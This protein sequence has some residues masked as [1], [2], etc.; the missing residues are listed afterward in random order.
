MHTIIFANGD[1]PVRATAQPWLTQADLIV[2]ADGGARHALAIGVTP[3]IVIGDLDSIDPG[4][5]SKLEQTGARF[6]VYPAHKD[7]TDLEL[8]IC[9]ALDHGAT[10]ITLL[11]ALGG[12][13]D[14]SLANILVLTRPA[15]N[16]ITARIVERHLSIRVI[17]ERAVIAGRVGDTLS[18][19]A[20]QGDAHGVTLDGCEYPL[21]DAMLPCGASLGISNVFVKPNVAVRVTTGCVLALHAAQEKEDLT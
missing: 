2:A 15:L 11:S 20:L 7:C 13:W 6:V 19:L 18:L 21:V 10:E 14:H 3:H 12:R 9:Y 17:R 5:R 1:P 16:R 8:A 4:A